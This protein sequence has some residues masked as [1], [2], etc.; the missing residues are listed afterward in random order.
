MRENFGFS[1]QCCQHNSKCSTLLNKSATEESL[2]RQRAVRC[3]QVVSNTPR[4]RRKSRWRRRAW[5]LAELDPWQERPWPPRGPSDRRCGVRCLRRSAVVRGCS[6]TGMSARRLVL[7]SSQAKRAVALRRA[8]CS[9]LAHLEPFK[10]ATLRVGDLRT[11]RH[12]WRAR[13]TTHVVE[14]LRAVV[15][16]R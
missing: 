13:S 16:R 6:W 11:Q 12:S 4:P 9:P 8:T 7:P 14:A 15:S 5:L 1:C 10:F 2:S 3:R